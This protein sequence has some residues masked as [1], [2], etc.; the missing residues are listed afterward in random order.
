MPAVVRKADRCVQLAWL[1]ADQA[2]RQAALAEIYP[3]A[4]LGVMVGSSRGPA[5]KRVENRLAGRHKYPP[6][7]SANTTFAVLSGALAQTFKLKGPGAT[8]SAT[9]ASAAFVIGLAAEQILL[10][11]AD[12]MLVGGAETPLQ[13]AVLAQLQSAGVLAEH[14]EAAHAC[15]PFDRA[16]NGLVP[17]EGGAFLILES[18]AGAAKRGAA[19]LA[20]LAGWSLSLEDSGRTGVDEAGAGL[21]RV[22]AEALQ[23]AGLDAENIDYINA[24]GTGTRLNDAAEARAI[25]QLFGA[26]A[27]VVPCSSTKPVTG[28]CLGATPALEAIICLEAMRHGMIPPTAN[29]QQP[30][31]ACAIHMQPLIAKPAAI[32][33]VMSNSLG[34]WGYQASLIFQKR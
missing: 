5:D 25:G 28:H 8:V 20:H 34:F 23:L 29:C 24:H 14:A 10:G 21:V 7:L 30:D 16:R 11:K 12:A 3:P 13:P 32:A 17:G 4:R 18:A 9:C 33:T 19:V 22:M 6:S 26:R 31:P 2:W 27:A 15:R 1:A